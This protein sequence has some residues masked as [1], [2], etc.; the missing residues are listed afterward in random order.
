MFGIFPGATS[1][2][3]TPCSVFQFF[4]NF[5][6]FPG[7]IPDLGQIRAAFDVCQVG[8]EP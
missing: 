6:E 1:H 8:W 5:S 2:T 7:A 4:L 3:M